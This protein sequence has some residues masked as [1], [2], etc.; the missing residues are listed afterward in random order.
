LTESYVQL[1]QDST[2]KKLRSIKRT[3]EGVLV[4]E[5]V[6]RI[7]AHQKAEEQCWGVCALDSAVGANKYHLSL[8]N[9]SGSNKWLEI[10]LVKLAMQATAAVAGFPAAFRLIRTSS[11]GTGGT[12]LTAGAFNTGNTAL[13][14]Q[15][16][17]KTGVST[18]TEVS[19]LAS[20][21]A[22]AEDT[23]GNSE[24]IL[25][26][27]KITQ[28]P[29]LLKEGEGI[30]VKQYGTANVGVVDVTVFFRVRAKES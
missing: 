25:F 15:V 9:G 27:E 5:Q 8:L 11:E 10:I 23:G 28:Q 22:T 12:A 16:S 29:L 7:E 19:T 13:P 2:G 4:E 30:T 18:P 14:A 24:T 3:V 21:S 26:N 17:A 20:G 1:P 6:I